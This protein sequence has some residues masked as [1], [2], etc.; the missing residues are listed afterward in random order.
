M[1]SWAQPRPLPLIFEPEQSG[2]GGLDRGNAPSPPSGVQSKQSGRPP[3]RALPPT[4]VPLFTNKPYE[5]MATG[6]PVV[7]ATQAYLKTPNWNEYEPGRLYYQRPFGKQRYI[8]FY[9]LNQQGGQPE[10]ISQQAEQEIIERYGVMAARLHAVFATYA[11]A[12]QQPWNTPFVLRG[13]DLIKTLQVYRTKQLNKAAK[14]KAI[15]DLALVVGTLGAVIHWYEG[16]LDLCVRERS[17]LWNVSVQEYGQA[18]LWGDWTELHEVIIRV[19][20]GLWTYNFLNAEGERRKTALYQY[21]LVPQK[22][23]DLNPH[24]SSLATSLGLYLVQN[25]RAHKNG[26]YSVHRLLQSVLPEAEMAATLRDRRAAWKLKDSFDNSLLLLRDT[27]GVQ[28]DFDPDTYP[29]WLRP[30][31]TLPDDLAQ[32]PLPERNQRLLGQKRL[33]DHALHRYWLQGLLTLKLPGTTQE[34]LD[35]F[36]DNLGTPP[37]SPTPESAAPVRVSPP[38]RRKTGRETQPPASQVADSPPPPLLEPS[39]RRMARR[40]PVAPVLTGAMVRAARKQQGMSQ[41]TLAQKMG[42]SQSWVRDLEQKWR[43]R[44]LKPQYAASLHQ[45]LGL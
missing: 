3:T 20:P 32:L 12:A 6:A 40:P 33:P 21:G 24:R 10:S 27:L 45:I 19:Q 37:S 39:S 14:L 7:S 29:L 15:A 34:G 36:R 41:T 30:V 28:L 1:S 38:R 2:T 22:L 26:L 17:L 31:W 9:I 16:D 4:A 8:E 42:R 44:P 18:N 25:S 13:S 43:D 35:L 23:F 11:A 5:M